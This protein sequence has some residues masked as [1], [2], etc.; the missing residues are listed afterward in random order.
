[1]SMRP[2]LGQF[3][4]GDWTSFRRFSETVIAEK[5][6]MRLTAPIA[7]SSCVLEDFRFGEVLLGGGG[8]PVDDD[9]FD[10]FTKGDYV[11]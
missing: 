1:M 8:L 2:V 10:I 4:G 11:N 3:C 6:L 5:D 7:V 9:P